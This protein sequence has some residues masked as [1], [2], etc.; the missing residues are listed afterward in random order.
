VKA[1]HLPPPPPPPTL[2]FVLSEEM[3]SERERGPGPLVG[4]MGAG[5]AISLPPPPPTR[6]LGPGF[7]VLRADSCLYLILD[8]PPCVGGGA[9]KL[10]C[11]W[12]TTQKLPGTLGSISVILQ[13]W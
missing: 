1:G 13:V 3:F 5:W 9:H 7:K 6:I 11:F 4:L 10:C 8:R 2:V 12:E